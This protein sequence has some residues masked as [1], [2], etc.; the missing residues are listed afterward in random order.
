MDRNLAFYTQEL[1]PEIPKHF[2]SQTPRRLLYL[3]FFFSLIMVCIW[4]Q[5]NLGLSWFLQLFV[6]IVMG[7]FSAGLVFLTHEL[8]HGQI[9]KSQKIQNWVGLFGLAPFLISPSYWRYWHNYLHHGNTQYVLKDPDA[10]PP[11]IAYKNSTYMKDCLIGLLARKR[12]AAMGISF[13]GFQLKR[14]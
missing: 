7:H 14:F 5:M 2:F 3:P 1:S 4:A 12:S 9:V 10:F 13:F 6:A 11:L 8:M